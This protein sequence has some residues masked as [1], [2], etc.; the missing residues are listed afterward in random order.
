MIDDK[1]E[2][3]V[4][5]QCEDVVKRCSGFLCMRDFYDKAGKFE[6]Y[7]DETRYMTITCG[8]CCGNLL[9]PKLE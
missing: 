9:T 6:G 4:I 7:S 3:V 2:L 8:G 1:P 5:I